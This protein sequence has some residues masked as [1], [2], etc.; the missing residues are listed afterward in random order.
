MSDRTRAGGSLAADDRP[1]DTGGLAIQ[2][3]RLSGEIPFWHRPNP[4]VAATRLDADYRQLKSAFPASWEALLAVKGLLDAT[5]SIQASY[6]G[7]SAM[8][9]EAIRP[10]LLAAA[11]KLTEF[12]AAE[13]GRSPTA[14]QAEIAASRLH[15]YAQT[16][17]WPPIVLAEPGANEPWLYCGPL[18][19]WM[20]RTS[21]APISLLVVAPRA[22]MQA[23]PDIIDNNL[24]EV[25]GAVAQALGGEIRFTKPVTPTMR[26][27]DLLMA[28]GE[29]AFGHKHFAHFLPLET[30]LATVAGPEFT[31]VFTNV[32]RH[33]L[34]RC[35]LELLSRYLGDVYQPHPT[36]EVALASLSWFRGHDLAHFWRLD[37]PENP[38]A[39]MALSHTER[40]TLEEGYADV[41]G[42]IS[43]ATVLPPAVVSQA[44]T[45][46][47]LRYMSR[48]HTRFSDS[49]AAVLTVG[50]L[51]SNGVTQA[52]GSAEWLTTALSPLAELARVMHRVR[53]EG[54]RAEIAMLRAAL[55]VGEEFCADLDPLFVS[56]PTDL[57]YIFG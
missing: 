32:H 54:R 31:L 8:R 39:A 7:Q 10:V 40:M 24:D 43:A 25:R 6:A 45:A 14:A 34:E 9:H 53:W 21:D 36:S 50:W 27:V 37:I 35:S 57:E 18:G 15:A 55:R 12:S 30:P 47:M 22:D 52:L 23:G 44:F 2:A 20:F 48:D 3:G 5:A 28:G 46:E 19:T 11:K 56:L 38:A 16:G 49:V 17:E 1:D 4:V 13:A 29:L 41:L 26:T 42:L 51:T 33:R